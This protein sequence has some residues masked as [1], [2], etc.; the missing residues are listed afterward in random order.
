[1]DNK[2]VLVASRWRTPDGTLL[3][4]KFTHDYVSHTDTVSGE[5]YFVDGGTA[6]VRMSENTVKMTDCCVWSTDPISVVRQYYR[7]GTFDSAGNRIWALLKNLSDGHLVNLVRDF[8]SSPER[9]LNPSVMQ[10]VRELAYRFENDITV[11]EHE[12]T[13]ADE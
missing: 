9:L 2:K 3:E 13:H 7:R 4:S 5:F 10:Y 8:S 6:Y 11:P 12:Y 1:M